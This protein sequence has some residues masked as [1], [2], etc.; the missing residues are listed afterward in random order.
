MKVSQKISELQT[1]NNR[2]GW[3]QFKKGHLSVKSVDGIMVLNL[4]T[5]SNDA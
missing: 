1:Q 2:V 4:C 3:S 5:S